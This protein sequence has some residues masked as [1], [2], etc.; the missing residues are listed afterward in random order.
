MN[1]LIV[2]DEEQIEEIKIEKA[3]DERAVFFE[4]AIP[5]DVSDFEVILL[6]NEK[7]SLLGQQGLMGKYI[8]VNDVEGPLPTESTSFKIARFNGWRT[9]LKNRVWEATSTNEEEFKNIFALLNREVLFVKDQPGLISA[10]V[11]S[12]IINE[13]FY[14]LNEKVSSKEE[15]DLAMKNGTNYPY[16]P[17]EWGE[18][19]GLKNVYDLLCKLS[20]TDKSYSPAFTL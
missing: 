3:T 14:A 20:E 19:I 8:I 15:I 1:I 13:A 7:V 11:I 9:F 2:G 12:R 6:L 18:K 16:G 5:E 10:R 17:F 4:Q